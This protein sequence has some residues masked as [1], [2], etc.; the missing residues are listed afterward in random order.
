MERSD[1]SDIGLEREPQEV[2]T[3]AGGIGT[4]LR[5]GWGGMFRA[6]GS[7]SQEDHGRF[8]LPGYAW[9]TAGKCHYG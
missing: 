6:R 7:R 3:T 8:V 2:V 4:G 1:L 9:N 5:I